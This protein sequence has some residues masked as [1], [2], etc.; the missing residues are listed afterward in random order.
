MFFHPDWTIKNKLFIE[1]KG[2]D[3][4][5]YNKELFNFLEHIFFILFSRMPFHF[6]LFILYQH[7]SFVCVYFLFCILDLRGPKQRIH[8]CTCTYRQKY[9]A[10]IIP[11]RPSPNTK[12]TINLSIRNFKILINNLLLKLHNGYIYNNYIDINIV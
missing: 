1:L 4:C 11:L 10:I 6:V 3:L 7:V 5:A 2:S 8:F 9:N 12:S